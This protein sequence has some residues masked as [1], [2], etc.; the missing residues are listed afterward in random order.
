MAIPNIWYFY[1]QYNRR[2]EPMKLHDLI[3]SFYEKRRWAKTR[4]MGMSGTGYNDFIKMFNLLLDKGYIA[5]DEDHSYRVETYYPTDKGLIF[6]YN[7]QKLY[8]DLY[9]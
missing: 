9:K 7:I 1:N 8:R 3:V 5:A 2:S 4:I 6:A